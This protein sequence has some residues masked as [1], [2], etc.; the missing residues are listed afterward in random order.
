M[1]FELGGPAWGY[2]Y[3]IGRRNNEITNN[4]CTVTFTI[5]AWKD[6]GLKTLKNAMSLQAVGLTSAVLTALA[7]LA[8]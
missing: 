7:Y 2:I 6:G 8:F 5:W 4:V 1:R 3:N